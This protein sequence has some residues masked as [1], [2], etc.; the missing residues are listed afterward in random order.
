[1]AM[2]ADEDLSLYNSQLSPGLC[3]LGFAQCVS[4]HPAAA[5]MAISYTTTRYYPLG[6][7]PRTWMSESPRGVGSRGKK[8]LRGGYADRNFFSSG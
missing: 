8:T 6:V 7:E 4:L 2:F 3:E 5:V 1:M